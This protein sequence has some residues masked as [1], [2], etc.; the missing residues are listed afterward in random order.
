MNAETLKKQR[1]V[2]RQDI[3]DMLASIGA[4]GENREEKLTAL[5]S[6]NKQNRQGHDI[7]L[8]AESYETY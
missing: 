2:T 3:S 6:L 4:P 5:A 1:K 7:Q 8:T